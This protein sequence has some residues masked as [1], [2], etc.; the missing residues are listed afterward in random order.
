MSTTAMASAF[1]PK[2]PMNIIKGN[3]TKVPIVPGAMGLNPEPKPSA[4]KWI[5]SR[6]KRAG[7]RIGFDF[8]WVVIA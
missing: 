3:D 7:R 8:E 1:Q 4:K 5:G 6:N 2:E